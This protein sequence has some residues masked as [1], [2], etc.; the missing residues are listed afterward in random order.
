VSRRHKVP[1]K[2]IRKHPTVAGIDPLK[3]GKFVRF[4]GNVHKIL[5]LLNLKSLV[6]IAGQVLHDWAEVHREIPFIHV[7]S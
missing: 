3:H 4:A 5:D 7:H 2:R 6:G 1:K